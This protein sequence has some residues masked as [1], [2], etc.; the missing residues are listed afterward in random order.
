MAEF[1]GFL[2]VVSVLSLVYWLVVQL[3]TVLFLYCSLC[4]MAL[5][6]LLCLC[7]LLMLNCLAVSIAST[8][9][10]SWPYNLIR[11]GFEFYKSYFIF[12][13]DCFLFSLRI[14]STDRSVD[15]LVF[16]SLFRRL[17]S[18]CGVFALNKLSWL[19]RVI[20]RCL[21]EPRIF[22]RLLWTANSSSLTSSFSAKLTLDRLHWVLAR[23]LL[24]RIWK[25]KQ[26]EVTYVKDSGMCFEGRRLICCGISGSSS[27][28]F[29]ER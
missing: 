29:A 7:L 6:W 21:A 28:G 4:M 15:S 16:G 25:M 22:R 2:R 24:N 18:R 13:R 10:L 8:D 9:R 23:S 26:K 19:L 20:L 27:F 14:S 12:S 1:F 3:Q 5:S 11:K 17:A